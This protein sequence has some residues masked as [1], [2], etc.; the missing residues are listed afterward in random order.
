MEPPVT[1][2]TIKNGKKP[3]RDHN[4]TLPGATYP[5]RLTVL[6]LLGILPPRFLAPLPPTAFPY[7]LVL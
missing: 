4:K 1:W 5:S 3:S 7:D 2:P 6:I